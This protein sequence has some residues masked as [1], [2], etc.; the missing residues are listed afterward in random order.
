LYVTAFRLSGRVAARCAAGLYL[1]YG[2]LLYYESKILSE[3]LSLLL[4]ALA[5]GTFLSSAVRSGRLRWALCSGMLLGLAVLAR[6]SLLFVGPLTVLAAALPWESPRESG[7]VRMARAGGVALGLALIFGGN[8]LLTWSHSGLFVPVTLVPRTVESSSGAAFDGKLSS[9]K[10][11][12]GLPSSYDVVQS[13]KRRLQDVQDGTPQAPSS[14]LSVDLR[15]WITHAP[16]KLLQTLNPREITFQ[17]G[18]NAERDHVQ[19]LRW[20]PVSFGLLLLWGAFGAVTWAR[21]RGVRAL[22]PFA[23]I[24]FGVF[25]TTTLAHPSTRYRLA[26][27]L[28]LMLLAAAAVSAL[29]RV[30]RVQPLWLGGVLGV[31]SLGLVALH[32]QNPSY[33]RAEFALQLAMSAGIQGDKKAEQAYAQRALRLAPN[34][35]AVRKR[36]EGMINRAQPHPEQR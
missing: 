4:A 21:E 33:N 17:Y 16:S 34:N 32:L 1:G 10:Y 2:T 31:A 18:F 3:T 23:P 26:M 5:L 28:P 15:G 7:R 20:L 9:I 29:L 14:A 19:V 24:V 6:A 13:A 22:L 35:P 12:Q 30:R 27:T 25:A 36:A 11:G 8:G